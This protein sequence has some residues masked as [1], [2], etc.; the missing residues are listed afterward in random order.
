VPGLPVVVSLAAF[1]VLRSHA[2]VSNASPATF[3]QTIEIV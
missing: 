1:R 2:N 3:W